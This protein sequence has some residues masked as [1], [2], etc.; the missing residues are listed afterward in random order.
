VL[1]QAELEWVKEAYL[2]SLVG[3]IVFFVIV[4]G[5]APHAANTGRL[6][7]VFRNLVLFV[8]AISIAD[9]LL[10]GLI[11]HTPYRLSESNGLLSDLSLP[12]P[13]SLILGFVLIDLLAYWL[14]RLSHQ[15]PW[16]WRLHV[17]HHSDT[18]LDSSTALRNHPIEL[19]LSVLLLMGFCQVLGIPLWVEG[20]RSIV[21]NPWAM[22]QHASLP[23]IAWVER[24]LAWLLATPCIHKL[25]HTGEARLINA[26]FGFVFSCWDRLFGTFVDPAHEKAAVYGLRSL[27]DE[28]WQT[29][30]GMLVTPLRPESL[31]RH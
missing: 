30:P 18:R 14:H 28:A 20:A 17:V 24:N 11:F 23:R 25:H 29:V 13:A 5:G 19:S 22:F 2:A 16:L 31:A 10:L 4:E 8:L 1:T 6:R 7:H 3:F 27:S 15:W 26:N 21:A 12:A 9:G